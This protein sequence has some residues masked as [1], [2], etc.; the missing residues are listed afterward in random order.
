MMGAPITHYVRSFISAGKALIGPWTHS[1]SDIQ[2]TLMYTTVAY[3]GPSECAVTESISELHVS[4]AFLP[5]PQNAMPLSAAIFKSEEKNPIPQWL[6][7]A[8]CPND[9]ACALEPHAQ[10]LP[11][12]GDGEGELS[13]MAG[14]CSAWSPYR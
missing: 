7:T 14:W 6:A 5:L 10:Q 9:P 13:A 12:G 8:G 3:C 1:L 11:E 4:D 2:F